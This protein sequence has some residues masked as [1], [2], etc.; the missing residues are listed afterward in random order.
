VR[1]VFTPCA[2]FRYWEFVI[3][4][5]KLAIVSVSVGLRNSSSYQL[6]MM[7]LVLFAAFSVHVK[8]NPY[9]SH[10]DRPNVLREHQEKIAT[11]P[12]HASLEADI[13]LLAKQ[14]SRRNVRKARQFFDVNSV[15]KDPVDYALL[16]ALDYNTVETV[17]LGSAIL[18]CLSGL[19]FSSSRFTGLL[20]GYYTAEYDGLAYTTIILICFTLVCVSIAAFAE[21]DPSCLHLSLVCVQIYYGLMFFADLMLIL[22]PDLAL[23][24]FVCGKQLKRARSLISQGKAGKRSGARAGEEQDGNLNMTMNPAMMAR[25]S[26]EF[27]F[28]APSC[29]KRCD[30][31][32]R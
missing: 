31:V 10:A 29:A 25:A 1:Y 28:L 13:R 14:N 26:C 18:V 30:R 19:M 15:S 24:L 3:L 27:A 2:S 16:V 22:K 12:L 5:R 23:S 6:A 20:A 4:A 11:D 9:F 32:H 21:H 7:L 8:N 17:L